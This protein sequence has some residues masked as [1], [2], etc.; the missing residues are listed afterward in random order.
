MDALYPEES[1]KA[2]F[3]L[4]DPAGEGFISWEQLKSAMHTMG[5]IDIDLPIVKS[6]PVTEQVFVQMCQKNFERIITIKSE[7][8]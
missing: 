8:D 3:R 7:K 6:G 4:L 2:Y 5:V 1:L